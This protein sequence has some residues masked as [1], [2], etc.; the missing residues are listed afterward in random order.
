MEK[1]ES[2]LFNEEEYLKIIEMALRGKP[3][4]KEEL[5]RVVHEAEKMRVDSEMLRHIL[6]GSLCMFEQDGEIM[7][8]LP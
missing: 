7:M 6:E 1:L 5:I 8:K 4:T 3:Q 2:N